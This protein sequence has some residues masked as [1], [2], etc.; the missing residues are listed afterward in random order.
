[1]IVKKEAAILA[2]VKA[3]EQFVNDDIAK[4]NE[5]LDAMEAE[6]IAS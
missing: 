5:K 1:M 6:K 3:K 2:S 4:L